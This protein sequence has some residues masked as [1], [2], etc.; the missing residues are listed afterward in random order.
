MPI[1]QAERKAPPDL[2]TIELGTA[3]SMIN[4]ANLL[5]DLKRLRKPLDADLRVIH[6]AGTHRDAVYAEWREAFDQGRTR[7]TFEVFL[8]GAFDQSVVHWI[9]GCVF[10]RFLE[11]NLLIERPFISGPGERLELAK[12][13]QDAHFRARPHDSDTEYL[14]FLFAEAAQ[15]PGLAGL[16]DPVHNPLFRLPLSGDG[17]MA[18]IHFFR[19]VL[20]ET[21]ELT[22]DFTDPKWD[23]RFLGD[24]Y[25]DLSEEARKRYALLQT[26]DFVEE[27]ILDRTLESA[28][29]EFGH[30]R[31]TMID[32][33]C[34]SGHFLLGGF[35]RLLRQWQ[36]FS[37]GLPPAKQAQRALDA[38]AGVDLNPFAVEVAR[39]RLLVAALKAADLRRLSAAPGFKIHLAAGDSLLHG[40]H[41][42]R[43]ELGGAK[44]G[45]RRVL[46]HHY[47]AEDTMEIDQILG[48]QYR[49]VVG[50]PPY[51]TPKDAAMREAYREI[52][53]SCHR[54][55]GLAAPFIERFF[56]LATPEAE[57]LPAG[58]VGLIVANS[59]MKREFG[60]K[61]IEKVLP[62]LDLTH[63]IDCSG[64]YIPG[65]GTP[66]AILF[67]RNRTPIEGVVRTVRGIR[68][69]P[70][71][72]PNPRFGQV[73]TAITAQVDLLNST[74]DFISVE[75]TP[76]KVMSIHPWSM[77]GGGAV[78][79]QKIIEEAGKKRLG[80]HVASI[81]FYQDTHADEA[82]VQPTDFFQRR[83]L[84]MAARIQVRGD[85]CRDWIA[86]SSESILFPYDDQLKQWTTVPNNFEFSW[87]W[88]L[89]TTLWNRSTFGGGSYRT[90]G[91]PWF[92]YHQFPKNR[93]QSPFL[94]AFGFVVT[95]NHFIFE[96]SGRIFNRSAPVMRLL[97]DSSEHDH[98]ALLGLLNSSTACFWLRQVCHSKGNGGI[99]GGIAAEPWEKFI[100]VTGTQLEAFPLTDSRPLEVTIE[101][102]AA[103][104]RLAKNM[105]VA[106]CARSVPTRAALDAS[107]ASFDS[108]RA[109]MLAQQEE[110]DWR[111]YQLYGL[112]EAPPEYAA[113]PPLRLG[114][115]AFE[116]V[117][118]RQQM[119]GTLETV[120][121]T[122]HGSTPVTELPANWPDDYRTVVEQRIALIESD[123][124]IGMIERPEFKRRWSMESWEEMEKAALR[125]WLLDRLEASSVWASADARLLSTNQLADFM[126]RDEDFL[127]VA[128]LYAQR[129]DIDI[130]SLVA[131]LVGKES[132]PF[133]AVLRFAD[134]GLR[135]W[136]QWELTWEKQRQED[137]I[138]A[139]V[140]VRRDEFR[141]QA[142]RR[143]QD[144]WREVNPRRTDEKVELYA[145]RMQA[146]IAEAV[147]QA[148][149]RLVV[150]E[151]ERRKREEVGDIPVPPKYITKDFQ[152]SDFWRLR[153][154]LDVPK[155]RFVSFPSCQRDADGSLVVTWAGHN[156]L[157]RALAMAAYYQ[158]RKDN[159]GWP[160]ERLVPLLAGVIELL[161]WLSQL[162]NDYDPVLGA[163]MGDY[164]VDFVQTEARDLGMTEAAVAAWTPPATPRRGRSRRIAA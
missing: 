104:Q 4:A 138:D 130:E 27:W 89:R 108:A 82:F 152:T 120:W 125:D 35:E 93:V 81:G 46:F 151:Q 156:H 30:E 109:S 146:G 158:E 44:E 110:L 137:A 48:R 62:A 53:H 23:T 83:G 141:A 70:S 73:W 134:T 29:R 25:Q 64:A 47:A 61:L 80:A 56:D 123:A 1:G 60:R 117:M 153:G 142:E 59:F 140:A 111:C 6:A 126:R 58:F 150:E 8:D 20:P 9:L 159:E 91:R 132:V 21:G 99:G 135:K 17:A 148:I 115:R 37:P 116:I 86:T 106:V 145:S 76:R 105:P 57:A 102:D 77:G 157:K 34:G 124:T 112:H 40:Q 163:R 96:R 143:A 107:R 75:D 144:Q 36:R 7:D 118:A 16:Y 42:F 161:P 90:A 28:I 129:P 127:S 121:F 11:D 119:A 19:D 13:R 26:P 114:E 101:L 74:S 154:G 164:F 10:L 79:V 85:D 5:A 92:D 136:A 155:E 43:R 22:H 24:L 149:N 94:I 68:G 122:R 78:D 14:L 52:Y 31:V 65:H 100:E 12:E 147:E 139:E 51:I 103:A 133:L 97:A 49:V 38:I 84:E 128:A 54:T 87:F 2:K 33:A 98:L 45:F 63:V 32:P 55:Y 131:D 71:T 67:G 15:L 50:N 113:P 66:T 18:L 162:H 69:E 160:S 3:L 39:F 41:F 95:H 72:P 88:A